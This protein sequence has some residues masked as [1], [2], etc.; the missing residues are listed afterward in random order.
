MEFI[1]NHQNSFDGL[2]LDWKL[3]K[4]NNEEQKADYNVEALV[5]QL[6]ALIV[7]G[8]KLNKDFPI[9]L[10]SADAKFDVIFS[11]DITGHDLFDYVL[12]KDDFSDKIK[13][14]IEIFYALAQGYKDI[15][16]NKDINKIFQLE[17]VSIIDYR[18]LDFLSSI[19]EKSVHEIVRFILQ[20][21]IYPPNFLIDEYL[22]ASRLGID[23]IEDKE[24]KENWIHLK[25]ILTECKYFGVFS[26]AWERWWMPKVDTFWYTNFESALGSYSATE[27][28]ELLNNRFGLQVKPANKLEM[29]RSDY[30]WTICKYTNR[31]LAIG[32]GILSSSDYE[33]VPWQEDEYYSP[34]VVLEENITTVHPIEKERIELLKMKFSKPRINEKK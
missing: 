16:K 7:E 34:K 21:I 20:K 4:K 17:D 1:I 5:Q 12:K 23:I 26:N 25:E 22:L 14:T 30:F 27:R 24:S 28:V 33:T 8:E 9:I 18:V 15:S 3:N 13:E 6:R 11:K 10:C 32:D 31:P 19:R 2:L 29:T